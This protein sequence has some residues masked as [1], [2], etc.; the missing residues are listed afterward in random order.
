MIEPYTYDEKF[1]VE[2]RH[3]FLSRL[4]PELPQDQIHLSES[5]PLEINDLFR[6]EVDNEAREHGRR[7]SKSSSS[8]GDSDRGHVTVCDVR[9]S[10]SKETQDSK[11]PALLSS[12]TQTKQ[13]SISQVP[14]QQQEQDQPGQQK[15]QPSVGST[16]AN[17]SK[18][19]RL[20]TSS[21][22]L[23]LDNC[24]P[25]PEPD[26]D[27]P[28]CNSPV[29]QEMHCSPRSRAGATDQVD[30]TPEDAPKALSPT[31][32]H[33][34]VDDAPKR[35]HSDTPTRVISTSC[36]Q[37]LI[38]ET[39]DSGGAT[40]DAAPTSHG[41]NIES[42]HKLNQ[43]IHTRSKRAQLV[44]MNLPDL[45]GTD[46]AEVKKFMNYCD[47]LTLGLERVLFVHS[48]GHEVFDLGQV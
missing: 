47:I 36:L 32:P 7:V 38:G 22:V 42:F 20:E 9:T 34:E 31:D 44:V 43:I 46:V 39:R 35:T 16:V 30:K 12:N 13:D 37:A 15:Q 29:P 45:W 24:D 26:E 5:I 33:T 18:S 48:T 27:I 25:L 4:H 2:D 40:P 14:P 28:S 10:K 21:D 3:K 17:S 19:P 1:R 8:S 6:L 41:D 11:M 23:N